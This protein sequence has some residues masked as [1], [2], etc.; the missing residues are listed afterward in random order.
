MV[1]KSQQ[2]RDFYVKYVEKTGSADD[3]Y[4]KA[5]FY[6]LGLTE[7]TRKNIKSLYNFEVGG[8][9]PEG[10]HK[11]WQTGT[12]TKVTQLAFNLFNGFHGDGENDKAM[13]YTPYYLFCNSLLPYMLEAIEIRYPEYI[14]G[15]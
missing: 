12:S 1:F 2:H 8:I 9:E 11:G 14:R 4:R 5:L 3:V 10:L 15:Y 6:T 7:E 13:D